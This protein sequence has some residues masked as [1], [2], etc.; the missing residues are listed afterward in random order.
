[1]RLLPAAL[2]AGL[3]VAAPL[4]LAQDK[5]PPPA[6]APAADDRAAQM[7]A[8]QEDFFKAQR[9]AKVAFQSAKTDE[10][11]KAAEAKLPKEA[12]FLPRVHKL[13]EGD[14]VDDPAAEALA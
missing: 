13:I 3:A 10:E 9:E 6:K 8:L 7:K 5:A 4:S 12:D 14:I 11:R 2:L 1:M